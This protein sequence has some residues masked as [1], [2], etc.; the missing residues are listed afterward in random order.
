MYLTDSLLPSLINARAKVSRVI[1]LLIPYGFRDPR[2]KPTKT[3]EMYPLDMQRLSE[4]ARLLEKEQII[5]RI[6]KPS[7]TLQEVFDEIQGF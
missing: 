7:Q 3:Y 5:V 4:K 1:V 2:Y 6:I